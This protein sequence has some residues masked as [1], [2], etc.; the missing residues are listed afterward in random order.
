MNRR[1]RFYNGVLLLN[2]PIGITSHDA[3]T[4]VRKTILQRRAGHTGTLDPKAEGL[5]VVCLG[6][7][8]KIAQFVSDFDKVYEAEVSLGRTSRTYDSE[9]LYENQL[10][11]TAPDMDETEAQE[12]LN[13]YLGRI[14]QQVP[15][16]SAV[17]VGGQHLYKMAR[18]GNFV[19]PPTRE[20][21]IKEIDLI[22]YEK[23]CL[24]F[25]VHCTKG[26]Y[27]RSLANDIG[28][29]LGCGAYLSALIRT[30]VGHLDLSKALTLGEVTRYHSNGTLYSH[31]LPYDKVLE[32]PSLYISDELL[33]YIISGKDV[34]ADDVTKIEGE[35]AAGDRIMLK[36]AKGQVLAIGMA[37]FD[38]DKLQGPSVFG[39]TRVL[40]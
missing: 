28:K 24:R 33:P 1:G 31:L 8:T 7:A 40:N 27:I 23:P 11:K 30:S 32:Y 18:E 22:E 38:H 26:T 29:D 39:Y 5:L 37:E 4:N 15:A 17:R 3:V 14:K 9:G 35:F 2:K 16:Y 10:P 36:N 12:V 13:K 6:R 20:V 19:E 21:E 34:R 25:R